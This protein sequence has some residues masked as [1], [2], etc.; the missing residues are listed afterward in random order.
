M[1]SGEPTNTTV[2]V[3][4]L[5]WSCPDK[6]FCSLKTIHTFHMS[7]WLKLF[8]GWMLLLSGYKTE[9]H[10]LIKRIIIQCLLWNFNRRSRYFVWIW[11]KI[12]HNVF[13]SNKIEFSPLN[14]L[15]KR[16]VPSAIHMFLITS[17]WHNG[18]LL[19][20]TT[21]CPIVDVIPIYL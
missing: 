19:K 12:Y 14:I 7:L 6:V 18:E 9:I 21:W 3:V 13:D 20:Q 11:K 17:N 1:L 10:Y 4:G 16:H 2:I 8:V 5:T 15:W